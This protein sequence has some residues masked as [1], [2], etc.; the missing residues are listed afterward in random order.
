MAQGKEELPP[1]HP[2]LAFPP[3][4][5]ALELYIAVSPSATPATFGT[6]AALVLPPSPSFDLLESF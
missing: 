3:R 2:G 1:F 4:D 6:T 5:H